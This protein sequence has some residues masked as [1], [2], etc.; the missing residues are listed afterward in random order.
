MPIY[1]IYEEPE[2]Y[3]HLQIY[4]LWYFS[5]L[6]YGIR[7]VH[8]QYVNSGVKSYCVIVDT[9]FLSTDPTITQ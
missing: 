7:G 9:V 8:V 5:I 1:R 6:V 2:K 4:G 3:K